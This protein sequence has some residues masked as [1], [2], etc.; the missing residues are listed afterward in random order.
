MAINS[1]NDPMDNG[2]YTRND[3]IDNGNYT[4][5]DPIVNANHTRNEACFHNCNYARVCPSFAC[6]HSPADMRLDGGAEVTSSESQ[7]GLDQGIAA[8]RQVQFHWVIEEWMHP[9]LTRQSAVDCKGLH[10]RMESL[11]DKVIYSCFSA[12]KLMICTQGFHCQCE[13]MLKMYNYCSH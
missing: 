5:N 7:R 9:V 2:N 13:K 8:G 1:A 4:R 11:E 10:S 12:G 6:R 3:P